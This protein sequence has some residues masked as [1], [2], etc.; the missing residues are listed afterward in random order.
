MVGFLTI[1]IGQVAGAPA[2]G[3]LLER[4][5]GNLAVLVFAGLAFPALLARSVVIRRPASRGIKKVHRVLAGT[6]AFPS[7]AGV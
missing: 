1:A 3:Y 6:L 7:E 2:F 5:P 4:F